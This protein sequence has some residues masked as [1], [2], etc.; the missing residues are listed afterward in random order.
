MPRLMRRSRRSAAL[1]LAS[2]AAV[3]VVGGASGSP[4]VTIGQTDPGARTLSGTPGWFVQTGVASG[5]DFVVPPGNWNITGWSTYA[6]GSDTQ[7]MSMMVFRPDGFGHY[8]VVGESPIESLTPGS[9]NSFADVNFAVQ[10]GD[11]LGL[12]APTGTAVVATRTA[13][14]GDNLAFGMTTT[15]PVVGASVT[16]GAVPQNVFR[17]NIS[18][19]LSPADSTAPVTTIS[20][21]PAAPNGNNGW[22]TDPVAVSVSADDDGGS[23]VAE[24]RCVLDPATPPSVFGDVPAG[25]T[26]LGAGA[27]V[28]SDGQHDVY[29][30]SEDNAGADEAPVS[31][32]FKIDGTP[33][34]VTCPEPMP[35]FQLGSAGGPVT[36]VVSDAGS[37]P[38]S[39]SVSATAS[40]ATA[41]AHA[42]DLTGED[43]A[44]NTTTA[45]CPYVVVGGYMFGGFSSPLPKSTVKSGSTLPLKF[46]LQDA[47]G[48]PISDTDAQALV[49]PSC[50]IAIILVKPAGPVPGCPSYDP[51]SKQFQLNLKT[52]AAMDGANGVSVSVTF[53]TTIVITGAVEPFTVRESAAVKRSS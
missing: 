2:V 25:C 52:T 29:A 50:K 11:R 14:A 22:Y 49:S 28:A 10:A 40:A 17:L 32:S 46:Q 30:A 38:V 53:D 33:P 12:Y 35:T 41:G 19:E 6:F 24:T 3:L 31:V 7:V 1:L 45:A 42:V 4:T 44:G 21:V 48:Q 15:Q 20:V 5:T 36:A 39:T 23:G 26:Y 37:G 8:D 9:L 27:D 43:E 51:I 18:A 16:P 13:A 34:T 47:S